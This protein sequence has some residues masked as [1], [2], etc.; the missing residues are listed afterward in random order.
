[1]LKRKRKLEVAC[2]K[3]W[4][5]LAGKWTRKKE[6]YLENRTINFMKFIAFANTYAPLNY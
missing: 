5:I 1:M 2:C 6:T 3:R 4:E